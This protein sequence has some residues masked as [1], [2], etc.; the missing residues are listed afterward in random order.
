MKR[1]LINATQ[2][3]ELRVAIVDGQT[4]YDLDIEIPSREQKKANIYKGRIT[5]VE[6][7]LEACFVDYGAERHGFLPLKEVAREYF[8][9]GLDPN[10]ANIRD[11]IKEG[12]E[13]VVQVEKEERGN[14]GAAL[15]TFI[16]LAGRYMVLM[17][18]NPKAGGVSR[19][20]EGEDRQALK[21][22]LE[23]LNVPD[24]VGLI[25]RTAGLGR[26][27]EEL[28]WD[29]DY[30]LQLWK[31]ISGAA[32]AQK[33]PFLI[34]QESKLFIR[35]LRDY[36]RNDIGEILIDEESLYNDAREFMQQVMPNALRKLKMYRD[37]TPL[38][39]RYQI[40]T[41]IESVFDR[42][43]RLPSGGS[44]VVDQ[45]EALTAI[46]I[47]SSKATKGS[48]IEETAFN[49]N[50]EAAVEI[51]RQLRIRDAGGLI[52]IDFIDMDSPKHQRE[53]EERL[54][55]A[56]KLDR[57]R[58][59]IG[60]ISRFGLLEMSR[61]R[62]RPSLGEATQIVC[63]RC[64]GHGHIR[65][66]ESLALSTLR[67]IEEHAMKDNTGQVL[68]QAPPTVANFMLNEKRASVVEIELRNKVHVVIVADDKLETPHIEIQRIREA[69]MGEHSKPSYER[70]T[71]VEASAVPKMGQALGSSE[72][73]A[74]S[75]IVPSSPAPVRE[76]S[77]AEPVA[78]A[79]AAR[80][81][82][83]APA[84]AGGVISRLL[85]WFRGTAAPAAPAPAVKAEPAGSNRNNNRRDERARPAQGGQPQG[86]RQQQ[87]RREQ[88]QQGQKGQQQ[89]KGGRQQPKQERPP[90]AQQQP[91]Q[92]RQPQQPK[93]EGQQAA[94]GERKQQQP[95]QEQQPRQPRQP[96][97]QGQQ[98]QPAATA[99][100]A[101]PAASHALAERPANAADAELIKNQNL[102]APGETTGEAVAA[103]TAPAVAGAAEAEGGQSRRRRG[104]RG[105]RRRR[106][107]EDATQTGAQAAES[108]DGQDFDD[109]DDEDRSEAASAAAPT[110][111]SAPAPA[112]VAQVT[113]A[114]VSTAAAVVH[115]TREESPAATSDVASI[116][117][118]EAAPVAAAPAP[119]HAPE[120]VISAVAPTSFNLPTLPPIPAAE[121]VVEYVAEHVQVEAPA[122]REASN[123][124]PAHEEPVMAT[125]AP[126]FEAATH[127]PITDVP[128][129][130]THAV[131]P[132]VTPV[133]VEATPIEATTTI[134]FRAHL[135]VSPKIE[136]VSA[137]ISHAAVAEPAAPAVAEHNEVAVKAEHLVEPEATPVASPAQ[138]DL[139]AH[140]ALSQPQAVEPAAPHAVSE[141]TADDVKKDASSHG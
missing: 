40:E 76:E 53:V 72:Q 120:Q 67:L 137:P 20:I 58:V 94:Q 116:K 95:R 104:R 42:Q 5:R 113:A 1:M 83:A 9:L 140:A 92:D 59:Q 56:L 127:S 63:P 66:V 2:R 134:D 23:H 86:N 87:Q 102:V 57:A 52:V 62:L 49:T 99:A 93:G 36:L 125:A 70:L 89:A 96:Q 55:D 65:G 77:A 88:P 103:D 46:D 29:L 68:V 78:Q 126:V 141:E 32:Q 8:T 21:E 90:Q 111:T 114:V 74:V 17:P 124:T 16:S 82:A 109:L 30:L 132:V 80:Q 75:G 112:P 39:S 130:T 31:A 12:H 54:K 3:E 133:A 33:A 60:R 122:F 81:P 136:P 28:Q 13:V 131:E 45:T 73:P 51:A 37:E 41:Q 27:A 6:P 101:A 48:D 18:N 135:D 107:H 4:L 71:A 129:S 43:V 69:D 10:K 15:T 44:I 91:K 25:V 139:L 108:A 110:A 119:V 24:D 128:A 79:P 11:L 138:G 50:L 47:N 38:F 118:E 35:A 98:A 97:G 61:Q 117:S 121:A 7:S 26:D 34:Y 85:G 22:A 106:R 64:E 115:A 84:P 105:G 19:R 14:K 100:A 123:A